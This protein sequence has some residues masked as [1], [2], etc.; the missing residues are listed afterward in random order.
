MHPKRKEQTRIQVPTLDS[1]VIFVFAT[2]HLLAVLS[3]AYVLMSIT[4]AKAAEGT[5]C[6][7]KNLLPQMEIDAPE[8]YA[9]IESEGAILENGRS[10]FWKLEKAGIAPSYLLGTMHMSDPRVI[11]MPE[12]ARQAFDEAATLI[13]ESN[14]IL[15]EKKASVKLLAT[16]DLMMF[17]DGKAITDFLNPEQ[18]QLVEAALQ[19]RGIPLL[20]VAKM[21]PWIIS[22]F[23]ALPACELARK[24]SGAP[25][26]D[27]KLAQDAEA[28]GKPIVGLETFKE[29]LETMASLPFDFHVRSL[30][31]TLK[32]ADRTEDL[33]ETLISLYQ[34]GKTGWIMPLSR[35]A[36]EEDDQETDLMADFEKKMITGR[37]HHMADRALDTIAKGNAFMAVGAL[38]LP[39]KEGLVELFRNQGY[40]VT[41]MK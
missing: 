11:A 15:D 26:L 3:L 32:Y 40:T 25:F 24:S 28:A 6:A 35:Y 18:K 33:M 14:E 21:K 4:P 13:L 1:M 16:P 38:H 22:S 9:K 23:V 8:T 41:S 7:G 31:S 34:D 2:L 30:V 17:T 36:F 20:S 19:K 10:I 5:A 37:N 12:G 27:M 29:Q 39:G